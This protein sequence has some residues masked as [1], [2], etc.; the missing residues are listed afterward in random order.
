[1]LDDKDAICA[2]TLA[3]A[4]EEILGKLVELGGQKHSLEGFIDTCI[5]LGKNRPGEP[6]KRRE[7]AE[8]AN[9]FRNELKHFIEGSHIVLTAEAACELIDRAAENLWL[10]EGRE[11]EQVQRYMSWRR[12][13]Q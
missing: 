8:I 9:Y 3:G 6:S 7:F 11:T 5:A 10:L 1:M 12:S 2:V 13:W 4:A